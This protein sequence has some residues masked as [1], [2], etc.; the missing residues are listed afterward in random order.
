MHIVENS[1]VKSVYNVFSAYLPHSF[2]L[3]AGNSSKLTIKY[4]IGYC[5]DVI[6]YCSVIKYNCVNCVIKGCEN[7]RIIGIILGLIAP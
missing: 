6:C 4:I 2:I 3:N 7:N 5:I 1:F